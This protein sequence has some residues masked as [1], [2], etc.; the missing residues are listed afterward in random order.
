MLE[1]KNL[2]VSCDG[3]EIIKGV[4]LSFV[5]GEVHALMGPNGSGKSTISHAIMGNPKYEIT[6]GQIILNGEDITGLK[7][8]SR[9]RKGLFLSF[10]HPPTITGVTI[11]AFLREAVNNLR[12]KKLGVVEFHKMLKENMAKLNMDKSFLKRYLND[13]FSGGEK[14]RAEM[15]Q[16]MML[17]PTFAFLDETDSGLD[18]DAIKIVANGI[19]EVQKESEMGIILITHYN[20]FLEFFDFN[21]VS[22]IV[23]GK[24][25]ATGGKELASRIESE[26]FGGFENGEQ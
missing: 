5:K 22:V 15:L 24:I 20:R 9:A 12:E 3:K 26:G 16:L 17:K 14:K 18:V 10:Q 13:G 1:I 2:H 7:A 8:D 11:S 21:K 6:S 4:S 25:A 19:K 23:N